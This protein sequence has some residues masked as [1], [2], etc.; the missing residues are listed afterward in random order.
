[1][2]DFVLVR[3]LK[4]AIVN[5]RHDVV[6]QGAGNLQTSSSDR[7]MTKIIILHVSCRICHSNI[8]KTSIWSTRFSKVTQFVC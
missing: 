3:V 6:F 7:Y 5:S 8:K 1:M 2:W 4:P